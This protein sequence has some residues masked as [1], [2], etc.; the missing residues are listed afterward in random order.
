MPF[1][2]DGQGIQTAHLRLNNNEFSVHSAAGRSCIEN[3][4]SSDLHDTAIL[5]GS[6]IVAHM[7][8]LHRCSRFHTRVFSI[9]VRGRKSRS[10]SC[11]WRITQGSGRKAWLTIQEYLLLICQLEQ[12]A[13]EEKLTLQVLK[14]CG[15]LTLRKFGFTSSQCETTCKFWRK[16]QG[17]LKTK[18]ALVGQCSM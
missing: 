16:S 8:K 7:H 9:W 13:I 2:S 12:H 1:V 17:R 4:C 14:Y 3:L 11:C 15:F 5:P 6:K 10:L 18:N